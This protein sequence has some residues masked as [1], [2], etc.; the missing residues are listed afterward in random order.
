MGRRRVLEEI[1]RTTE[2]SGGVTLGHT[3]ILQLVNSLP[4]DQNENSYDIVY[5]FRQAV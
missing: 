1:E 3:E 2:E 5:V 4:D